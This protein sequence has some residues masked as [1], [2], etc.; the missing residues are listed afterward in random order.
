MN[1]RLTAAALALA[2]AGITACSEPRK[3]TRFFAEIPLATTYANGNMWTGWAGRWADS[4]LLVDRDEGYQPDV[5]YRVTTRSMMNTLELMKSY[6]LDGAVFNADRPAL[7]DRVFEAEAEGGLAGMY[8]PSLQLR[9]LDPSHRDYRRAIATFPR[10]FKN[11][12]G[13]FVGGKP[14]FVSWW[15]DR[16][17]TPAAMAEKLQA[18]RAEH[19]DFLFVTD[20]SRLTERKYYA[21]WQQGEY[22]EAEAEEMRKYVRDYLRVADGVYFGEYH[23]VRRVEA[24]ERVLA[25]RYTRE[26]I[27]PRI[28]EVMAEPEFRKAGKLLGVSA[29]LGHGNPY[30]F[31]NNVGQNGTRTLRE[32]VESALAVNPDFVVFF[33]WDEYNE[34]TLIKP[35]IWNSFAP[36]RIIRSLIAEAR[37]EPVTPL[38]GDNLKLPNLIVSYRKT[39]AYGEKAIFEILNLPESGAKGEV[40]VQLLLKAPGGQTVA[41]HGPARLKLSERAEVRFTAASEAWVDYPALVPELVVTTRDEIRRIPGLPA[42]EL[43]AGGTYDHKWATQPIRDIAEGARC[44]LDVAATK[45]R[46]IY[47]VAVKAAAAEELDRVELRVNGTHVFTRGGE[48]DDFRETPSNHVF[49]LCNYLRK[50][51]AAEAERGQV[52]V[53]TLAGVTN[54][55]WRIAGRTVRGLKARLNAQ[56]VY[57]PDTYLRLDKAEARNAELTLDWPGV[58][59]VTV[60][61]REVLHDGNWAVTGTNGFTF[62][63]SRFFGFSEYGPAAR[64]N[65]L[66]ATALVRADLPVS[67]VAATLVTKSGKL[68][69]SEP[70]VLGDVG[71]KR[72]YKLYSA[73]KDREVKVAMGERRLPDLEWDIRRNRGAVLSSGGGERKDGVLGTI[74]YVATH[75]NRGGASFFHSCPELW[76]DLPSRSPAI[77]R[78]WGGDALRFDGTGTFLAL[79][80]GVI[81]RYQAYRLAFQFKCDDPAREQELFASGTSKLYGPVAYLKLKDGKLEGLVCGEYDNDTHCRCAGEVKAD[82]WN[83][84]ELVWN[85]D[86]VELTLNGESSGRIPCVM[87]GRSDTAS[88]FGGRKERLFKGLIRNVRV[89]YE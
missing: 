40:S 29:G 52:P 17:F 43:M 12:K 61:L 88:W 68:F 26:V 37:G 15:E 23:G 6:A 4:L 13:W 82:D 57:T 5:Y 59:K 45:E 7:V 55:E 80:G 18:L 46:G 21:K 24:G 47:S 83:Q 44:E 33:E 86:A 50:S 56:S 67:V 2:L 34:N 9:C 22:S 63:V 58:T 28:A 36:K 77:V 73:T 1:Q 66:S 74:P 20:L 39:L 89:V 11:P 60:K 41:L 65:A 54:A 19:G 87:P 81:P 32:S 10:N 76:L 64:T 14:V 78:E 69:R 8:V 48:F 3:P 70:F 85:V 42:L 71:E 16:F 84:V 62:G 51:T 31:G 49:A 27:L 53:Y 79:P 25:T 30:T 72:M 75:V 35:T 38:A